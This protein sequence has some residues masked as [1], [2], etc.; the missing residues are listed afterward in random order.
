MLHKNRRFGVTDVH[1]TDELAEKLTKGSWTCCT[2][3]RIG[4]LLFLNDSTSE[5]GAQEY[6][7]VREATREQLESITFG[8][9]TLDEARIA[10]RIFVEVA[11]IAPNPQAPAGRVFVAKTA[12]QLAEAIGADA[13]SFGTIPNV[14]EFGRQHGVCA[15]CA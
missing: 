14:V 3:F 11:D 10:I 5:N 6:A 13:F 12:S 1:S 9:M 8:W 4:G 15:H 2:G 7:V